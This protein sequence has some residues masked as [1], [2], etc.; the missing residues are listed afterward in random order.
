[1]D[2]LINESQLKIILEQQNPHNLN[3]DMNEL[4]SFTK[5]LVEKAKTIYGIN[6]KLLLTWGAAVGG[7][8]MPLSDFIQTGSFDLSD[9]QEVLLLVGAACSFFYDNAKMLRSVYEK[10]EMEGLGE[11][12]KE[13]LLKGKNLKEAFIK[14]MIASSITIGSLLEIMGYAFLIPIITD[15]QQIANNNSDLTAT[16]ILIAKRL[17]ASGVIVVGQ[18]ALAKTITKILKKLS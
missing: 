8:V 15:L 12:F 9:D 17:V 13:V 1:M 7:L 14:F 16:G 10:I 6:I 2:F 11:V 3:D 18:V 5:S 4:Y